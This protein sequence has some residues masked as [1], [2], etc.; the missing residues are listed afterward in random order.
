CRQSKGALMNYARYWFVA[1]LALLSS[2]RC[3]LADITGLYF[4]SSPLSWI[5]QGQTR[6]I[7]PADGF[8]FT[9][10]G[11]AGGGRVSISAT[12]PSVYWQVDFVGPNGTLPGVGSYPDAQREGT[13][14]P[15]HPGLDFSTTGRGNNTLTGHFEV[16]EADFDAS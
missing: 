2:E 16:L 15:G 4:T 1:A 5:G 10:T 14:S 6:L 7:T 8:T 13:Q 9:R 3:V 12:S 11:G